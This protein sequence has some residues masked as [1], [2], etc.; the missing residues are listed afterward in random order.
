MPA[1]SLLASD[2]TTQGPPEPRQIDAAAAYGCV[3]WYVY[4]A[5]PSE[6]NTRS[7][8]EVLRW[9]SLPAWEQLRTLTGS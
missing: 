5:E 3:D 6:R 2:Q 8:N 4:P 7:A 9:V 1:Y